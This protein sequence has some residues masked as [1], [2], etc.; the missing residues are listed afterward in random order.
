M[1]VKVFVSEEV[2]SQKFRKTNKKNEILGLKINNVF[3]IVLPLISALSVLATIVKIYLGG[4]D[5]IYGNL[6]IGQ[7]TAFNTYVQLFT[8]PVLMLALMTTMLGQAMASLIESTRY[9]MPNPF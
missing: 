1:L 7:I 3:A 5:V 9:L 8:M 4:K 6:T 2:E